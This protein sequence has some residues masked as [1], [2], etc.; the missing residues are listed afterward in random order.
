[1]AT[2]LDLAKKLAT[3]PPLELYQGMM[4]LVSQDNEAAFKRT[5]TKTVVERQRTIIQK[6]IETNKTLLTKAETIQKTYTPS[7]VN[8]IVTSICDF[9]ATCMMMIGAGISRIETMKRKMR[10]GSV[11]GEYFEQNTGDHAH[12]YRMTEGG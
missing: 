5:L 8:F 11:D 7:G 3:N 6:D 9:T 12:F 10:D 1:M 2:L 4:T